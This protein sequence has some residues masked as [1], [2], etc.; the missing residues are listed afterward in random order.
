MLPPESKP[1]SRKSRLPAVGGG[2]LGGLSHVLPSCAGL[3]EHVGRPLAAVASDLGIGPPTTTVLPL[4]E[5]EM[6]KLSSAA[7]S[8]A[9]NLAVWVM[10][11]QAGPDSVNT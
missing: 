1:T 4:I 11:F 3:R 2:E 5:T 8:D 7:P 10:V 9:V 6:P